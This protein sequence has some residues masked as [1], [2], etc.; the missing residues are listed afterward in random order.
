M[1]HTSTCNEASQRPKNV[2]TMIIYVRHSLKPLRLLH[3][4]GTMWHHLLPF[5][6]FRPTPYGFRQVV[7]HVSKHVA[8]EIN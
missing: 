6:F 4:Q 7:Q 2:P 8:N 5:I 3:C 1:I